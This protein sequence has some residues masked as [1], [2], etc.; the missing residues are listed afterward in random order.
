MIITGRLR[1]E[2][3]ALLAIKENLSF[4]I[5]R[6][7]ASRAH[8]LSSIDSAVSAKVIEIASNRFVKR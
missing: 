7:F 1:R 5:S 4:G 2:N 8:V 6:D 3:R